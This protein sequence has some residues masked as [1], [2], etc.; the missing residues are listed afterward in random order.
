M[1]VSIA[2][3]RKRVVNIRIP[4]ELAQLV[5]RQFSQEDDPARGAAYIRALESVASDERL[6]PEDLR[7]INEEM[8]RN[9]QKNRRNAQRY[10]K[11]VKASSSRM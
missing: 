9:A 2:N 6:R 10:K 4:L 8:S 11:R 5:E 7:E 1:S 3:I